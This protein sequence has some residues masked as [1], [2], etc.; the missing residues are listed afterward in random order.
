MV[1]LLAASE[2]YARHSGCRFRRAAFEDLEEGHTESSVNF[3]KQL[4]RAALD[5][6]V[7][8]LEIILE[9]CMRRSLKRQDRE[10]SYMQIVQLPR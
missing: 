2:Q 9:A 1:R 5:S 6:Q 10:E 3:T 7:S 4:L 8:S